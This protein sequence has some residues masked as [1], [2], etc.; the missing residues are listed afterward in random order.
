MPDD[1][2]QADYEAVAASAD[3]A[4]QGCFRVLGWD[5]K[6]NKEG[7]VPP[8][9]EGAFPALGVADLHAPRTPAHRKPP[10]DQVSR[11]QVPR[12]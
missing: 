6:L 3:R 5:V 4:L 1:F 10:T 11:G 2:T 8:F 9:C 7:M 12:G